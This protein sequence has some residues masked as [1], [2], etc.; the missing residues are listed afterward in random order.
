M[1]GVQFHAS[2]VL[3]IKLPS[4]R[5]HFVIFLIFAGFLA[6]ILRAL[7]LQG[8][9]TDFLQTQGEMR[10]ART[11]DM[12]ATRGKITD[13]HGVILASSVPTLDVWAIP[14]DVDANAGELA[15]LAK[16]LD[17]QPADL[18]KKL[19]D[20]NRKFVY[21]KRQV[22]TDTAD[23][24]DKLNLSGVH[25]KKEF[26]RLYSQGE[27]MAHVLGFTNV[28]DI[29]QEGLELA[30]EKDLAGQSGSRR[31]FKDR[32]GRVIEDVASIRTPHD[33][34][35]LT[36]AIDGQIQYLA[37]S[38]LKAA[39]EA[40][41]AKAGAIVVVD[42]KTGEI[43]ALANLPTYN[44]NDRSDLTGAQLRNRVVTD[45]YEPGSTL[46]P[47]TISL[48]LAE[49]VVSPQTIVDTAPGRFT[50][51]TATI[52]DSHA[53]G[54]L[55]V[56]DII[57][58][59]SNIGTAKVA[60]RL[61]P[62]A[63]WGMFESVGLGQA[64]RIGFPGAAAG[65]L[66][67]YKGW[68]PIEQATMAYGYGLSVSLLQMARAYT[69]F[70]RNGDM[71]PLTLFKT[72]TP[73]QGV[74]V[75]PPAIAAEMR[76]MLEAAAG[77]GGTAPEAQ[78]VGYRVAGKTGTA[79]KLENG[80]YSGNKYV[81]SFVGFAPVSDPRI[82]V[83]VMID[84]PSDGV[85]YGGALSGP[86]FSSVVGGALRALNVEPDSAIKSLIIPADSPGETP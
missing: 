42:V 46:K 31:V 34:R 41:H 15:T 39:V 50:I 38:Q 9:S 78:V 82:V 21:L 20:P 35:D 14:E 32:L 75:L 26:H 29:G 58:V 69:I 7:Y 49:G 56:A 28:E 66:R 53:H 48:A 73:A 84:E 85:Y 72:D 18:Q 13:R 24:I 47:F 64:P 81:G 12:P 37:F 63:M 83:A 30:W 77:P 8:F 86:V 52:S 5:S 70:A 59:S 68:R 17:I 62:E 25:E 45:T 43:L 76:T 51:G 1:K 57:K 6:L 44:P 10:Y 74:Q 80:V 11:L 16:L 27:T 61:Q 4:W 33:G 65:R 60:L 67:P 3:S 19:S 2:P 71:I 23:A 22:S 54:A 36:L 40:H 55:S 79:H